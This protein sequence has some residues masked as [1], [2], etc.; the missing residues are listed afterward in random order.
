MKSEARRGRES[1]PG[2]IPV[3]DKDGQ[4]AMKEYQH[5]HPNATE[6]PPD[7][8][9][10]DTPLDVSLSEFLA[11]FYPDVYEEIRGRTFAPKGAPDDD[12]RFSAFKFSITREGLDCDEELVSSLHA[13]NVSRGL[14]F[15]IN[16]G[17]DTDKSITRYNAFFVESDKLSIAEQHARLDACPI[18]PSIRVETRNSVHAYWLRAGDC[19]EAEWRDIQRRLIAY[20]DGDPKIKNPSRVMRLPTLNHVAYDKEADTFSYKR[21]EVKEFFPEKRFT[22]AEMCAAFPPVPESKQDAK[23]SERET[24]DKSADE[25]KSWTPLHEE[26]AQRV[27]AEARKNEAGNYEMRC[28]V[29]KGEGSTSLVHFPATGKTAC[30]KEECSYGDV[31]VAFGLPA[32]PVSAKVYF[33][34]NQAS[35]GESRPTDAGEGADEANGEEFYLTDV[36][37]AKRLVKQ[38]GT[39]LRYCY[40][41]S[42]W[43]SWDGKRWQLDDTGE[44]E[45]R[46]KDTISRVRV[47]AAYLEDKATRT[48][49]W[50]HA[51]FSESDARLRAM[52]SQARSEPGVAVKP[53]DLDSNLFLLTCNNG[54]LNLQTGDLRP[55]RQ[56]DLITKLA[57][58]D[59]EPQ[60]ECPLWEAFLA[61]IMGSKPG[62]INFLR[63]AIGY[64]LTGDTSERAMF[65][66]YGSGANGKST[67]LE[68]IRALLGDYATRTPAETLLARRDNAIPNDVAKL[69]GARFVSA[70]ETDEGRRLAEA[71]IKDLTGG[72]TISARFMRA[73]WF[74]FKPECKLWLS[75]NH[76]PVVRGTDRAIWDRLKLVPF[77]VRIPEEK[78]DRK[79]LSKLKAELP[80]IL[81]WAVRGCLEWQA[82]GLGVPDEVRNATGDYQS[83]MDV[84]AAFIADCCVLT[85]NAQAS[86]TS[87][88]QSYKRWCD[89]NGEKWSNQR[90]FGSSLAERGFEKRRSGATGAYVWYGI[91]RA[92]GTNY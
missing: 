85:P 69:K 66:M 56:T 52:L 67:A 37:N 61:T 45:R 11:P 50:N 22:V 28:P 89:D 78:Q 77:D 1:S 76:K 23:A 8:L 18:Q 44:A 15:V 55:H 6:K 62:L 88:Y 92:E 38:H 21:V 42:N 65:I 27:M 10:D 48:A 68:T 90:V 29:H 46:A 7:A 36:G 30:L 70:S 81:A 20:F 13:A 82:E 43:L 5:T 33:G 2:L 16:A 17:G 72:D 79:L 24:P 26:L 34:S 41:F 51:K 80:G 60:A 87:L 19:S 57:P 40:P 91:G 83:E 39:S 59:Y 64:S 32:F 49:L 86:A 12:P 4:Q 31:L 54:T 84:L 3:L 35:E 14:Y 71:Q 9:P 75:T 58:V 74:D 47:E 25:Y 63:R 73:E 53:E